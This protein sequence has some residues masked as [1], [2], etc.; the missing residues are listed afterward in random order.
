MNNIEKL[1]DAF[2]GLKAVPKSEIRCKADAMLFAINQSTYW[3]PE[4]RQL[5]INYDKA[6]QIFKLFVDNMEL[7]D[8]AD[9][10]LSKLSDVL[11]EYIQ[12]ANK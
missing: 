6:R 8:V 11:K 1:N 9:E 10:P 4:S 7:P 12:N 5:R 3:L 2:L